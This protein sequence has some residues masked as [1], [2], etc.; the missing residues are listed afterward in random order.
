MK[1]L[2]PLIICISLFSCNTQDSPFM[3]VECVKDSIDHNPG[4]D[5]IYR[6]CRQFIFRA[7]YWDQDYQLISDQRIWMM[8]TGKHWE[9][10]EGQAELFIQY[11]YDEADVE[12]IKPYNINEALEDRTWQKWETTGLT[13]SQ[14]GLWVHPFRSNQ[15]LFTE[16]APFPAI[17]YVDLEVGN[18]WPGALNIHEGWGDWS[19]SR[20]EYV[21]EVTELTS[22][23]TEIGTLNDCFRI[24]SIAS[25]TYGN[26]TLDYWFHMKYGLVKMFYSNYKGQL[27]QIELIE[28][29]ED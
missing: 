25:A 21:Y 12:R 20:V 10:D 13:E 3:E 4:Y 15:Y 7:Q 22:L 29:I 8:A 1:S 11:E 19:F 16:V 6:P 28:V 14:S 26:S 18:A 24:S 27:L 23:D 17:R 9:Y 5:N 2:L